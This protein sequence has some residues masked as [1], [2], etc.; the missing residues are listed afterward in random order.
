MN[1]Y[2]IQKEDWTRR[3]AD[4]KTASTE[5]FKLLD[6]YIAPAVIELVLS[7]KHAAGDLKKA[8]E[9]LEAHYGQAT[10]DKVLQS[11]TASQI[12]KFVHYEI[13]ISKDQSFADY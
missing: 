12:Y 13:R 4:R 11:M 9:L 3:E 10:P 7:G 6:K 1:I 8:W 2:K 5:G